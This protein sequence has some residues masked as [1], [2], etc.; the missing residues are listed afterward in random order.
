MKQH[1]KHWRPADAEDVAEA[2]RQAD[3]Q[4]KIVKLVEDHRYIWDALAE[5]DR[6]ADD[7][8]PATKTDWEN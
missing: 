4:A 5:H 2:Q 1:D 3:E 8:G 7:G 6:M